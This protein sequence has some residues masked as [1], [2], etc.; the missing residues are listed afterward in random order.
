MKSIIKN[1]ILSGFVFFS[2]VLLLSVWYAT[3]FG[4]LTNS[5][6]VSSGSGLSSLSWNRIVDGVLNLDSRLSNLTFS[7]SNVGIGTSPSTA[8]EVNGKIKALQLS[9]TTNP[10]SC[11]YI[12]QSSA[13]IFKWTI[14]WYGA[15][16]TIKR[17][18]C[19]VW[20]VLTWCMLRDYTWN[21]TRL[22]SYVH[23]YLSDENGIGVAWVW[24]QWNTTFANSTDNDAFA[25]NLNY[26]PIAA[27]CSLN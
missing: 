5:D 16:S 19:P 15:N 1:S 4:G 23:P 21:T 7:G 8:L 2:T 18:M 11:Q 12:T 22:Y 10:L 6:K 24:C 17:A 14:T 27:C 9:V 13:Y 26:T 25:T 20:T 3:L